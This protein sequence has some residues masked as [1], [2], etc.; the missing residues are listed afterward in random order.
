LSTPERTEPELLSVDQ[1]ALEGQFA[2]RAAEARHRRLITLDTLHEAH[3]ALALQ[4]QVHRHA[5][6]H[7]DVRVVG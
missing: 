5:Q 6:A 2:A 3:D 1:I 7:V 4:A